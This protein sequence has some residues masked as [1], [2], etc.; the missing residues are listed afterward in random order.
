MAV[1]VHRSVDL[2]DNR[3]PG[4]P[5]IEGRLYRG[6]PVGE[7]ERA[8]ASWAVERRSLADQLSPT[9]PLEHTHWDWRNKADSVRSGAHVLVAIELE[10]DVQGLMA[11]VRQPRPAR[12][13][14]G[15][16][17]YVD[18]IESAPW[19][20]RDAWGPPRFLALGTALLADAIRMSIEMGCAGRVGLHS[21]PQAERFYEKCLM[22]RVGR[23]P[24]YYELVYYEYS[25]DRAM[26]FPGRLGGNA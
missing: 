24:T 1:P 23:D 25:G 22:T 13:S 2:L 18:Y 15:A 17:V 26:E 19:N 5:C 3:V 4:R 21:L 14:A 11:V 8:E 16:L 12:L 10:G 9:E 6:A 20:L 7:L